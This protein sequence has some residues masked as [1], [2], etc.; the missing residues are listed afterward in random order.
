MWYI[1]VVYLLYIYQLSVIYLSIYTS[2]F[3]A[4][5]ACNAAACRAFSSNAHILGHSQML[6]HSYFNSEGTRRR[7]ERGRVAVGCA[8]RVSVVGVNFYCHHDP[9]IAHKIRIENSQKPCGIPKTV[10]AQC[11]ARPELYTLR[12]SRCVWLCVCGEGKRAFECACACV[13]WVML[14][15][16]DCL[17]VRVC[18]LLTSVRLAFCKQIFKFSL[19]THTQ[20]TRTMHTQTHTHVRAC[21]C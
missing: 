9:Q 15:L 12:V 1:S 2:V 8:K 19:A 21:T 17:P 16:V 20:Q 3:L 13:C 18:F 4:N 11:V 14:A 10:W 6:S 7:G 5:H